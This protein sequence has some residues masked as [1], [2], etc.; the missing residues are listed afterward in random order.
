VG[1]LDEVIR[2]L[3]VEYSG[4]WIAEHGGIRSY[5]AGAGEFEAARQESL[6]AARSAL[7]LYFLAGYAMGQSP[8]S[9]LRAA[10][11]RRELQIREARLLGHPVPSA[12]EESAFQIGLDHGVRAVALHQAT[13]ATAFQF[14]PFVWEG[15]TAGGG[16]TG[17]AS[18][19]DEGKAIGGVVL[20]AAVVMTAGAIAWWFVRG[21]RRR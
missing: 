2:T 4:A 13:A 15:A 10:F 17:A 16:A 19:T 5:G 12:S 8:A 18:A 11:D 14:K 21:R 1:S 6:D 20:G 3:V 7:T 9:E